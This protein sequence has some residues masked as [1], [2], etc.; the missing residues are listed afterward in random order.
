MAIQNFVVELMEGLLGS[1]DLGLTK[2]DIR[3]Y[4]KG[5]PAG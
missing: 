3:F 4:D 5:T 2:G 1:K